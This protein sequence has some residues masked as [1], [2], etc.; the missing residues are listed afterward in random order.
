VKQSLEVMVPGAPTGAVFNGGTHFLL[1]PNDPARFMFASED[2]TIS[3]WNPT[4]DRGNAHEAPARHARRAY[5]S[6]GSPRP[7]YLSDDAPRLP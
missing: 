1:A 3:A 7:V 4:F 5:S 6:R 2:G